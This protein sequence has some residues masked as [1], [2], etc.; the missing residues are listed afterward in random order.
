MS[1]RPVRPADR[2]EWLRLLC[3]LYPNHPQAE[4]AP[5]VDGFLKGLPSGCPTTAA[6]FVS[7]RP[8]AGLN[9]FVEISVRDYAQGCDGPTPHVESW[10][11][12]P[13][14]RRQGIGH[15]LL[16]A[17]EAW[18][19]EHGFHEIASDTEL[20]NRTSE[21]AHKAFGFE[22]VERSIHFRKAL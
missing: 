8:G 3:A 19:R 22:E 12:D 9:G 6:V 5:D 16:R 18:A 1:I 11:V 21:Q 7:E 10:F 20:D 15:A 13:D 17:S 14:A 2:D 4:H